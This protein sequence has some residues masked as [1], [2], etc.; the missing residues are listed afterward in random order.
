MSQLLNL[1][2]IFFLNYVIN[3]TFIIL[4]NESLFHEILP[5]ITNIAERYTKNTNFLFIS[6]EINLITSIDL[7]FQKLQGTVMIQKFDEFEGKFGFFLFFPEKNKSYRSL[8][9]SIEPFTYN[10]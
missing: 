10:R 4:K 2:P 3:C 8:L 1:F 6:E 7:L 9:K 5:C